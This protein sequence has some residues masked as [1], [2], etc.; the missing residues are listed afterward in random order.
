MRW[1]VKGF[2]QL[3]HSLP[4]NVHPFIFSVVYDNTLL[5]ICSNKADEGREKGSLPVSKLTYI[6]SSSSSHHLKRYVHRVTSG[7]RRLHSS[8]RWIPCNIIV[9][10]QYTF[11]CSNMYLFYHVGHYNTTATT[12][13]NV[14]VQIFLNSAF[15]F[16]SSRRRKILYF[17]LASEKHTI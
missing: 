5:Q 11:S 7:I 9:S 13:Q 8:Q 16:S 10:K 3:Y 6:P 14:Q 17:C 4:K 15:L 12:A 1:F 2:H